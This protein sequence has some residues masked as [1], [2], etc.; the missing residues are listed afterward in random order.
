MR[1]KWFLCFPPSNCTQA[2]TTFSLL[3]NSSKEEEKISSWKM[4]LTQGCSNQIIFT[5]FQNNNL[6]T[7]PFLPLPNKNLGTPAFWFFQLPK[8]NFVQSNCMFLLVS[9]SRFF[10][11]PIADQHFLQTMLIFDAVGN[12][13]AQDTKRMAIWSGV[14]H[15]MISFLS[16]KPPKFSEVLEHQ[17][18]ATRGSREVEDAWH[19]PCSV[20]PR[21]QAPL[22]RGA[23]RGPRCVPGAAPLPAHQPA[24][25]HRVL[26]GAEMV[27]VTRVT[28]FPSGAGALKQK[29]CRLQIH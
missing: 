11:S 12:S 13:H 6:L 9:T 7:P 26:G 22:P 18:W 23:A 24:E 27:T 29:L 3:C 1:Q 21:G 20:T 14:Y 2:H 10:P 4:S 5:S 15:N 8:M 17:K 28:A 25:L 16:H 19:C